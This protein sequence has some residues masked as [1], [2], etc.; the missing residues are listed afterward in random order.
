MFNHIIVH[1]SANCILKLYIDYCPSPIIGHK[2]KEVVVKACKKMQIL[3]RAHT[4][5]KRGRLK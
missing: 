4:N 3:P 1:S 5:N 2:E